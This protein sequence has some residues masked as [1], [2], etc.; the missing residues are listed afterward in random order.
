MVKYLKLYYIKV[1]FGYKCQMFSSNSILD[2]NLKCIRSLR[3]YKQKVSR[4]QDSDP[5]TKYFENISLSSISSYIF[6]VS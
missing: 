4:A 6:S 5:R 3:L 1:C 2:K